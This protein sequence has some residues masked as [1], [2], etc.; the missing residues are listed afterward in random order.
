MD[1]EDADDAPYLPRS[2]AEAQARHP[3]LATIRHES[4]A[5]QARRPVL[6]TS[7]PCPALIAAL[8]CSHACPSLTSREQGK[9]WLEEAHVHAPPCMSMHFLGQGA[10]VP[11]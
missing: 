4:C 5:A 8:S 9:E 1:F 6:L 3:R 10:H 2:G 11:C 7:L